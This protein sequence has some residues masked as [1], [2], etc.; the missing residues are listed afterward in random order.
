MAPITPSG[1]SQARLGRRTAC[2][3]ALPRAPATPWRS[4][5]T[6]LKNEMAPCLDTRQR[7]RG[8]PSAPSSARTRRKGLQRTCHARAH[9]RAAV[10]TGS[11]ALIA[12]DASTRLV[13]DSFALPR[14]LLLLGAAQIILG[15]HT[16]RACDCAR[17]RH[18]RRARADACRAVRTARRSA[19]ARDAA[20]QLG[21][22]VGAGEHASV[23]QDEL[24]GGPC[25]AR[26]SPAGSA[27]G[28][29]AERHGRIS[30]VPAVEGA[31][32][33]P[34]RAGPAHRA[35]AIVDERGDRTG[36]R[37]R[38]ASERK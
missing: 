5:T 34:E 28:G 13:P 21:H 27:G 16:T 32:H 1:S 2:G 18:R 25:T 8:N 36:Q 15:V 30:S 24:H 9:T 12:R 37:H 14:A 10:A 38:L 7:R 29:G 35:L 26:R 11:Y 22:G 23:G 31:A 4:S 17:S 3:F 6:P 19:P 20:Q 33:D